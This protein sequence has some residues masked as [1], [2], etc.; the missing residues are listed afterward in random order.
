[1]KDLDWGDVAADAQRMKDEYLASFFGKPDEDLRRGRYFWGQLARQGDHDAIDVV[2][3]I[4][5]ARS[6]VGRLE[7]MP[8]E[9]DTWYLYAQRDR[10]LE[11]EAERI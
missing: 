3:T 2:G 9:A 4:D 8:S 10:E 6:G 11:I 7:T 5:Y 1:M